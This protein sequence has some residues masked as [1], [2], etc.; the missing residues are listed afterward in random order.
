LLDAIRGVRW[1][2][3]RPVG[4]GPPGA[5]PSRQ[6]GTAPEFVEYRPY[7]QGD[8]PRRIDWKLLARA[9]RAYVRLAPDRAVSSTVLLVDASASMA[10][11]LRSLGKWVQAKRLAVAFAA[12]A[13]A[14]GD[15]VGLRVVAGDGAHT[16]PPRTRRGTVADVVRVLEGVVPSGARAL[17]AACAALP[18]RARLVVVSDLLGAEAVLRAAVARHVAAGGE[19]VVLHVVS[20]EELAPPVGARTAVDP[21]DTTLRR[22]LV[23]T[24]RAAYAAAFAAWRDE[25]AAAWRAV[26]V[27]H[28][29]VR[30]DDA[31]DRVVRAVAAGHPDTRS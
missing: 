23:E 1:P 11:P 25:I 24:T 19:A 31:T 30:D 12:V 9:D 13:H 10:F 22:P 15:P 26:G 7:R 18:T 2:A 27:D 17:D 5:H 20:V 4:G 16:L 21:E 14:G 8:D 29:V 28:R 6:R 3:R